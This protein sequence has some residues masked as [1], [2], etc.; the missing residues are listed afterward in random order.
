MEIIL[1]A[2]NQE[3]HS[4][5]KS[6][7][8]YPRRSGWLSFFTSTYIWNSPEG[9]LV[10][11]G[12]E[13]T[14]WQEEFM[15]PSGFRPEAHDN[16]VTPVALYQ[17][18]SLLHD[19]KAGAHPIKIN[20]G[21]SHHSCS[22]WILQLRRPWFINDSSPSTPSSIHHQ[23][24]SSFS[25]PP[26]PQDFL[27]IQSALVEMSATDKDHIHQKEVEDALQSIVGQASVKHSETT[28]KFLLHAISSL[29][30]STKSM[31]FSSLALFLKHQPNPVQSLFASLEEL[32]HS[33]K[34]DHVSHGLAALA[35]VFQLSP[36][37][38]L[39]ILQS[40]GFLPR[41]AE[42]VIDILALDSRKKSCKVDLNHALSE[43]LALVMNQKPARQAVM[44]D[45]PGCIDWLTRV[46]FETSTTVSLSARCAASLALVKLCLTNQTNQTP[47]ALPSLIRL[48]R[49]LLNAFL[50]NHNSPT[51]IEGLALVS[52]Q[53]ST[54]EILMNQSDDLLRGFRALLLKT[55]SQTSNQLPSTDTSFAYGIATILLHLTTYKA[56]LT[57][58]E[59]AADRLRKLAIRGSKADRS[60][61]SEEVDEEFIIDD[62]IVFQW[63]H[64]TLEKC[65]DL[66][67]T[68]VSLV[69]CE[70]KEVR[71]TTGRVLFNLVQRQQCRGK[72]LQAGGGR[73][74]MKI[75]ASMTIPT[76]PL[77]NSSAST[78]E[79]ASST[80]VA[81]LD[82]NDLEIIQALAKLLITTNPLLIFGPT[83]E[84]PVLLSTIQPLVVLLVHPSATL[85]Q[86]FEALMAL[87]NLTSLGLQVA[88]KVAEAPRLLPRLEECLLGVRTGENQMV[89]RAATELLCNLSS[90]ELVLA[91]FS[92]QSS[93]QKTTASDTQGSYNTSLHLLIALSSSEDL[94]TAMA[95]AGCL[96]ILTQHSP[97]IGR[98]LLT[99]PKL[100][101]TLYRVSHVIIS[102]GRIG[103]QHRW[104]SMLGNLSYEVEHQQSFHN[105]FT[106][107]LSKALISLA[108]RLCEEEE[109][110]KEVKRI[111]K[112]VLEEIHK[113]Q[114][115]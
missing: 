70:S 99:Q 66:M 49:V 24:E 47:T 44:S 25:L 18:T 36:S 11:A 26:P 6:L 61:K 79:P 54:R 65:N 115:A 80:I 30:P 46:A 67:D 112:V 88:T 60:K 21:S 94:A 2:I 14:S 82:C 45:W 17:E 81:S 53:G 13:P 113:H 107:D 89:R 87:T 43:F 91:H 42:S 109:E 19:I 106:L 50:M 93:L 73:L 103:V 69:K 3:I 96:A 39:E 56:I 83:P 84:S 111:T 72:I 110:S 51:A 9:L 29:V 8:P 52:Q 68:I 41:L 77:I 37:H 34:L 23:A 5:K 55:G 97:E 101:Q 32:L 92:P 22:F 78:P 28:I 90:T 74:L 76:I 95:A 40:D 64:R 75:I 114:E 16:P 105:F 86:I 33:T 62:E 102:E 15:D 57:E 10:L 35:A 63:I 31:A 4:I 48:T 71:R 108:E 98:T 27:S 58:E 100:A 104:V 20:Q 1:P 85:L 12:M 7:S 59:E 38:G